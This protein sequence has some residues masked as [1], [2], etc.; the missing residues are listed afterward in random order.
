MQK[1]CFFFSLPITALAVSFATTLVLSN[2]LYAQSPAMTEFKN[3][4]S[5]GQY[6]KAI[7]AL[8]T[9]SADET[10]HGEKFYQL[11]ECYSK[12]QEYD[13]AFINYEKAIKENNEH[14][15]L[16]YQYGQALYAA[17][18]LKSSRKAFVESAKKKFN[19][20]ASLYYIAHISQILEEFPTARE[21]YIE[22]IKSK[23]AD[24]KIKQIAR[25][26]LAETLLSMMKE[27]ELPKE[28][29]EKNIEKYIL[30]ML[31]QAQLTDKTTSVSHDIEE[32][33]QEIEKEYNLDPN[34]LANGRRISPKRYSG[35]A[36]QKIKFDD[37]IT[38]TNEENNITQSKKESYIFESEVY[39]KYDWVLK[40]RFIVSPEARINFVQNSDQDASEVFQNDTYAI[41]TNLKTK[42]EHTFH[43]APASFLFDV[44][45]SKNYKDWEKIHHRSHYADATTI[46]VG[47]LFS[48]F[49]AGDTSFKVKFK[50]YKGVNEAI[51]NH[52]K[53]VSTD[54][55]F[56][57]PNQNLLIA[58]F[59]ADYIDNYNNPSTNTNT[60]LTRFDYLIPEIMPSYT[61]DIALAGTITDTKDQIATRGTEFTLNPSL[62]LSKQ[63]SEKFRIAVN[64]DFTKSNSK[65]ADYKYTKSVFSTEF[66]Y[67]F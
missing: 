59:E 43:Q 38:L 57:L 32:R 54:Q 24:T 33:I 61:L 17:N 2:N 15:N 22:L 7:K 63:I 46:G 66:R 26:Q 50:N 67:S 52:T 4:Y 19:V 45:Y 5:K 12:L 55:T 40:K 18:E 3:Y 30:P 1:P 58:L 8:E 16:Y 34:L 35:Y 23:D 21:N 20:P 10:T 56:L 62:D 31:K 65:S 42:Y 25:F 47:E 14:D 9:I 28:T 51:S 64:Y 44:E 53:S 48:Y 36:V 39:A 37:N 49:S 11:G 41:N 6:A 27:K 60:Y 13:K 29:T